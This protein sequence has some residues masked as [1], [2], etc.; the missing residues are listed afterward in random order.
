MTCQAEHNYVLEEQ[1]VSANQQWRPTLGGDDRPA[2]EMRVVA[3]MV[4][5][6]SAFCF[7]LSA[8]PDTI[9]ARLIGKFQL[10]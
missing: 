1:A 9:E 4:L 8:F 2:A 10:P 6:L 3:D 7:L 5:L